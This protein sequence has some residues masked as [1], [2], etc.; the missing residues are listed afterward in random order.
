VLS[1]REAG[2]DR[3]WT[4]YCSVL[5]GTT[6]TAILR[7]T[8]SRTSM[9]H[10]LSFP[11]MMLLSGSTDTK[12]C[13]SFARRWAL[14]AVCFPENRQENC[15]LHAQMFGTSLY[16]HCLEYIPGSRFQ[17]WPGW[18][19]LLLRGFRENGPTH[20]CQCRRCGVHSCTLMNQLKLMIALI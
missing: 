4:V 9:T 17:A 19:P 10:C 3:I 7:E 18:L 14:Y 6:T 11:C 1:A 15:A 13:C 20:T 5:I 2:V 8:C 12:L 16:T